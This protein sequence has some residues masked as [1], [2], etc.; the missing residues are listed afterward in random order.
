[1]PHETLVRLASFFVIFL[2]MASWEFLAPLRQP[3]TSRPKR[4]VTNLGLVLLDTAAARVVFPTAV[5][6]VAVAVTDRGWGVLNLLGW[7]TWVAAIAA[8]V[9]L[10]FAVYLQ[11][12]M[13]HA[14]PALWRV[15]MAH[16]SDLDVDVTT[17]VRFH[18]IET[19][20]SVVVKGAVVALLGA[21]P[22]AVLVFEALL[23]GTS[24]FNH[25]NV[26]VP[27][28][29]D[30]LLRWVVVTPDMHRI[31]HSL[32]GRHTNSN[33]GFNLPL[34]DRLMGTYLPESEADPARL[35]LGVGPF[36]D[37]ERLTLPW[38]LLLP[39]VRGGA[40]GGSPPGLPAGGERATR[41]TP[42]TEG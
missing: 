12:V 22:I 9:A 35:T 15:H 23:N 28:A 37:P 38:V 20:I 33:Y 7:P 2:L 19:L 25:S 31:H 14:I 16:H 13:F 27:K 10:D 21:P 6:G 1:M 11:H 30:R 40:W 4:W 42:G 5:V 39:F 18:P 24:L 29:L 17:G 8:V 26:R 34:W 36:R 41:N 3:T 32:D